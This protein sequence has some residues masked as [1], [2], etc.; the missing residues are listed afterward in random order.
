MQPQLM[1]A[2]ARCGRIAE[3]AAMAANVRE[4]LGVMPVHLAEAGSCFGLCMAAVGDG[5][6]T[7]ELTPEEKELRK[8]YLDLALACFEE[9]RQKKYDD[10]LFLE[11]DADLEPLRGVPEYERWLDSFRQSRTGKK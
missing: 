4:N 11:S 9:A 10:I 8:Q 3:A 6:P 2:L 5:K 1:L 7:A